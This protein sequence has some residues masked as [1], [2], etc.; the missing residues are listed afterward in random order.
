MA[1]WP[2]N[3]AW[4]ETS[5]S[6]RAAHE[7]QPTSSK[8]SALRHTPAHGLS[9]A[10]LAA[11]WSGAASHAASE[12]AAN[13][14]LCSRP[15]ASLARNLDMS[16]PNVRSTSAARRSGGSARTPAFDLALWR[17]CGSPGTHAESA[18]RK[19]LEKHHAGGGNV[20]RED[21]T[22]ITTACASLDTRADAQERKTL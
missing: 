12:A 4:S 22:M 5:T 17:L 19:A 8:R 1:M 20:C 21:T 14:A 11:A 10:S 2:K 9:P 13:A 3:A 6:W 16:S 15:G 7:P 18:A